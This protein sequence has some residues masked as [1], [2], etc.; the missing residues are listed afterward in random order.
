MIPLYYERGEMGYSPEW[1][2]I[3]KR[4]IATLLPR[5][6]ST[7]MVG[8]YV[9]KFYLPAARQG[10]RYAENEFVTARSLAAWKVHIRR[11]WSDVRLRR[12]DTHAQHPLRRGDAL[13]DRRV[14]ERT[15]T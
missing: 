12:L 9:G 8:E 2:R 5:F 14:P 7:R 3:A 1:V 15:E 4:S 11:S 10:R 6:N 13:R